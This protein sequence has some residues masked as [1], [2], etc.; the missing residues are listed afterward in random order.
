MVIARS[1]AK[2]NVQRRTAL[3]DQ[4]GLRRIGFTFSGIVAFVV[5]IA[6]ATGFGK[7]LAQAQLAASLFLLWELQPSPST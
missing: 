3:A 1:P 2:E 5:G 4:V 6:A 7:Y